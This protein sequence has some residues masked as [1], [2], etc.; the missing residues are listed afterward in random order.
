MASSPPPGGPGPPPRVGSP[1]RGPGL[2]LGRTPPSASSPTAAAL[3]YAAVAAG[4]AL[5]QRS[6]RPPTAWWRADGQQ[7]AAVPVTID[8]NDDFALQL[9]HG[10]S[11]RG[12]P[13]V[14]SLEAHWRA[15]D[16]RQRSA[17]PPAAPV[18]PAASRKE[19]TSGEAPMGV[20]G[21]TRES[22]AE[23]GWTS[24][25]RRSLVHSAASQVSEPRC[26]LV[27]T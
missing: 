27:K 2:P 14:L 9:P 16:A 10:P 8:E 19:A 24:R 12:Q 21:S 25:R 13:P 15:A 4:A 6:R 18:A 20:A 1:P 3:S 11:R 23:S 7:F 17:A 26:T 5:P 22:G